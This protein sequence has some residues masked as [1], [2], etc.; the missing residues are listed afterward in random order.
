[1]DI[2]NLAEGLDYSL[3]AMEGCNK[4][5]F[6]LKKRTLWHSGGGW[7]GQELRLRGYWIVQARNHRCFHQDNGRE[8][9]FIR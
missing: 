1:M 4:I 2:L 7:I 6:A 8:M 9:T 5:T 3:K